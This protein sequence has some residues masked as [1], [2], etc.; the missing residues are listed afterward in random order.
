MSLFFIATHTF[1]QR[2]VAVA[3]GI[4]TLEE[5][6]FG[7]TTA[8]GERVDA[9][10]IYEL[11]RGFPYLIQSTLQY[12]D[13]HLHLRAQEGAGARPIILQSVASG[14]EALDQLIRVN[15]EGSLTV[16]GIHLTG[17]TS[18]GSYNDR[19]IRIN[20]DEA[21]IIVD[22]CVIEEIGQAG[23][24]IQGD[25]L[26]I[27]VINTLFNR[28]GRTTNPDNG[29]MFD[30][31]GVPIDTLWVENCVAYNVTSRFYRQGGSE[32]SINWARFNQNTFWGCGQHAF[33]FEEVTDLEFTNNIVFNTV[34][35]GRDLEDQYINSDLS[36]PDPEGRY[37]IEIDTFI[38]GE[39]DILISHN[40][41]HLDQ[42]LIDDLPLQSEFG[43]GD[44]LTSMEDF[45]FDPEAQM[46]IEATGTADT[47]IDEDLE[48][49]MPA[50][51]PIDFMIAAVQDTTS[52]NEI[53]DAPAWD[54]SDLMAWPFYST[55]LGIDLDRYIE[56][57]DFGYPSSSASF[58]AG[59]E[60]QPI[61]AD[62]TGFTN[63]SD[64]FVGK[65][66]LY[67]P[68]PTVEQIMIQNL[69]G[70]KLERVMIFDMNG[71]L[72]RDTREVNDE[73]IT[74]DTQNLTSGT[75]IITLVDS[76]GNMSSKK[77]LKK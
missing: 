75:Y 38:E 77:F 2:V 33:D 46:A 58:T 36:M 25:D 16:E 62:I 48:F 44:T 49:S 63:V 45:V 53:P 35:F 39:T 52:G 20:A 28:M 31:R 67:Y 4:G 9:N 57:H 70:W 22:D 5:T 71:R 51:L 74:I 40:N 59:T 29:R 76:Q 68:N 7:D 19:A 1:A 41:F 27:Y 11:R 17:R 66:I 73:L 56:F 34:F 12:D 10:T 8:T 37:T 32:P 54:M 23:I 47:N 55:G 69:E 3:P 26:K 42:E 43:M 18:L 15:G 61:G 65:N 24:R 6:I 72:M 60:G 21:R 64:V 14:G 50:P 30:N 13:F